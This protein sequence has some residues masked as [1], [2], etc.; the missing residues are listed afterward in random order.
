MP[1]GL[2]RDRSW[3][4]LP[5]TALTDLLPFWK[6]HLRAQS[7]LYAAARTRGE[8]GRHY[9]TA[10]T[11]GL[12]ALLHGLE[13]CATAGDLLDRA[14]NALWWDQLCRDELES[15]SLLEL[16]VCDVPLSGKGLAECALGLR[17]L[18]LT[19]DVTVDPTSVLDAPPAAVAAWLAAE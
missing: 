15:P 14:Q 7:R 13:G 4:A 5:A 9:R 17:Y 10:V 16:R 11:W 12:T 6:R 18:E 1:I 8:A 2:R 3:A 19:R